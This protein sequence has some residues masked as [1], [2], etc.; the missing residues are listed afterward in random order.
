MTWL[1]ILYV[2]LLPFVSALSLG[3]WLPLPLLL[4]IGY[5]PWVVFRRG[6]SA[7][8]VCF[9]RDL[10]FYVMYLLGILAM[11][12]SPVAPGGKSINYLFAVLVTFG[13]F[14]LMARELLVEQGITWDWIG[15]AARISLGFLAGAV[16]LEFITASWFGK[17]ISDFIPFAHSDLN[18]SYLVN[19]HFRRP[20]GFT[21][22]PGFT[23][24]AFECLWPLTWIGRPKASWTPAWWGLQL[25]Y[26]VAFLLLAS[27]AGMGCLAVSGFLVWIFKSRNFKALLKVGLPIAAALALIAATPAGGDILWTVVGRKLHLF[28]VGEIEELTD[29]LTAVERLARYEAGI[30]ILASY[31]LGVGWGGVSE[32]FGQR[33][34]LTGGLFFEGT[35]LINLF[36]D[37]AVA[38]GVIGLICFLMFV[39]RKWS[40]VLS[41]GRPLSLWVSIALISVSLHHVFITEFH[42][43]FLWFLLALADRVWLGEVLKS[44]P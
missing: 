29:K 37:F 22:E 13:F 30:R 4:M 19:E 8:R 34:S 43:P 23:A 33:I 20:R 28:G 36:L 42:M 25:I 3:P 15:R 9:R 1:L 38:S 31:P 12:I 39:G 16:I 24:V 18:V 6:T 21:K 17:F 10:P 41:N 5:A 7:F 40:A 26:L 27:A 11:L 44:S 2:G 32:A 14:Y 35:G